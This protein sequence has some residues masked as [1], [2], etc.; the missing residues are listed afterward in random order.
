MIRDD[1]WFKSL[2][3]GKLKSLLE[4]VPDDLDLTVSRVN[5]LALLRE[6]ELLG[7]ISVSG[8]HLE[9]FLRADGSGPPAP[10]RGPV[11]TNPARRRGC[12]TQ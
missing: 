7:I 1:K 6:G 5:E 2:T 10:W 9:W 3:V 12:S 4:G 8:E 11:E